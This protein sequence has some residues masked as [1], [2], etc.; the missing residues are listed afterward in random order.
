MET[1]LR[2]INTDI[3]SF[4]KLSLIYGYL[5]IRSKYASVFC[6]PSFKLFLLF[7]NI[8]FHQD[9]ANKGNVGTSESSEPLNEYIGH[10]KHDK[11]AHFI[12]LNLNFANKM[13]SNETNASKLTPSKFLVL[14]TELTS[15]KN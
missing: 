9:F 1:N 5:K 7:C 12:S 15:T 2:H 4:N 14:R 10:E 8:H 13:C 3:K 6:I 11:E